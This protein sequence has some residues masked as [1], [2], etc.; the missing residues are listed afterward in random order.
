MNISLSF[1]CVFCA[2][3]GEQVFDSSSA[4]AGAEERRQVTASREVATSAVGQKDGP[5][6]DS[7]TRASPSDAAGPATTVVPPSRTPGVNGSAN[8]HSA[9][10]KKFERVLAEP[11]VNLKAGAIPP[12]SCVTQKVESHLH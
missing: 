10:D 2:K 4:E 8:L 1:F 12:N 6:L 5:A 7:A 11:T 3:V 9:R